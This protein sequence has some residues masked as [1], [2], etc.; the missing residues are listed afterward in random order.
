MCRTVLSFGCLAWHQSTRK[1]SIRARLRATQSLGFKLMAHFRKGTPN[2]RLELI[3]DC[4]PIEVFLAKMAMKAYFKTIQHALFSRE[5]LATPIVSRIS[6]WTCIQEL[7]KVQNLEYTESPLDEVPLYMRWDR[8]F[9]TDVDSMHPA[10]PSRGSPD[11]F[12]Y[13]YHGQPPVN[14][15]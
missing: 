14:L 2:S 6:H 10:N 9:K 15:S 12:F 4:P 13:I 7:I 1:K 11:T 5:Q 3:F 8:N